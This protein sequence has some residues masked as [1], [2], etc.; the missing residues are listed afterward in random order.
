MSLR[1]FVLFLI[2]AYLFA[3]MAFNAYLLDVTGTIAT[4]AA[5]EHL[6]R[7]GRIMAA[8]GLSIT[9]IY[10]VEYS[11]KNLFTPLSTRMGKIA[12]LSLVVWPLMFF[13]ERFGIRA[14]VDHASARHE[15]R[16]YQ[17]V[18]LRKAI[19]QHDAVIPGLPYDARRP[20]AA[21]RTFLAMV[22][23]LGYSDP[24]FNAEISKEFFVLAR[25]TARGAA[26]ARAPADY[27]AYR[28]GWRVI[29]Q[30]YTRYASASQR[31]GEAVE[32]PHRAAR[33]LWFKANRTL[34]TDGWAR[35]Q[36]GM[37]RYEGALR[38][39]ARLLAPRLTQF[40]AN[41]SGCQ[42]F[43]P[44][45]RSDV[46][47][48]DAEMRHVIAPAPRWWVWCGPWHADWLSRPVPGAFFGKPVTLLTEGAVLPRGQVSCHPTVSSVLRVLEREQSPAFLSRSG[49]FAPGMDEAGFLDS[50]G[51]VRVLRH[52]A[53]EAGA[54]IPSGWTVS[55]GKSWRAAVTHALRAHARERWDAQMR[56]SMG[57]PVP[58]G[59]TWAQFLDN[60]AV[61]TRIAQRMGGF[62]PPGLSAADFRREVL[63]PRA[64]RVAG[65]GV[66]DWRRIAAGRDPALGREALLGVLVPPIALCLSLFFALLNGVNVIRALWGGSRLRG[67]IRCAPGTH[68]VR[69]AF[70]RIPAAPM[71]VALIFIIAV[72]FTFRNP[73][74]RSPAFQSLFTQ[75]A[76]HAGFLLWPMDW[77]IRA[78][79]VFYTAGRPVL[80][81][82][83]LVD[84]RN[85]RAGR[86]S[87][88]R[89]RGLT[90]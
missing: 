48:Y 24:A 75:S 54:R 84:L 89:P 79:P 20:D 52:V 7:L 36:A 60:A 65:Q 88:S 13:G 72:P 8:S 15:A 1:R 35:Y 68:A 87:R 59:M 27:A 4:R 58:P 40:Y 47:M 86:S 67:A 81:A 34:A 50:A 19:A 11:P 42:G 55:G 49:G 32:H 26:N 38:K 30:D 45:Q 62:I 28:A 10:S 43:G 5:I 64:R 18:W 14:L 69:T 22:G 2:I 76:A 80:R 44:C 73:I 29:R 31:F 21:S 57:T 82:G 33:D 46:Q 70:Q 3:E 39:A 17:M 53:A 78:E 12:L 63:H 16:A 66:A 77:L 74:S 41:L 51:A 71:L 25:S 90:S 6:E 85:W 37:T 61:R 83:S 9:I 56:A 23:L